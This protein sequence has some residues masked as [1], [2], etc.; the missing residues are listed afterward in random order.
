[1]L[2]LVFQLFSFLSVVWFMHVLTRGARFMPRLD[3]Q[4]GRLDR[5]GD[6]MTH[7]CM[8]LLCDT[9]THTHSLS[10]SLSLSVSCGLSVCGCPF[11]RGPLDYKITSTMLPRYIPDP[12]RS[13]HARSVWSCREPDDHLSTS[14]GG[15]YVGCMLLLVFSQLCPLRCESCMCSPPVLSPTMSIMI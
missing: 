6:D 3:L 12:V 13:H 8:W 9:H 4:D 10:L 7:V 5:P 15:L 11:G 14:F 1:M 2:C